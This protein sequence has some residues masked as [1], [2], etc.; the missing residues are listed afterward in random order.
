MPNFIYENYFGK[1]YKFKNKNPD[2]CKYILLRNNKIKKWNNKIDI[3]NKN[4][5][6]IENDEIEISGVEQII[7]INLKSDIGKIN[8]SYNYNWIRFRK[9][10]WLS[11]VGKKVKQEKKFSFSSFLKIWRGIKFFN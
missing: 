11:M 7:K 1:N 8:N 2:I 10:E 9:I 5:K 4:I 3:I 6:S